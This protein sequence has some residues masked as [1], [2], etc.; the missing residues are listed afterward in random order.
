ME[1]LSKEK[2]LPCV[3]CGKVWQRKDVSKYV[4]HISRGVVCR[5]HY[6]VKEW[7]NNLLEGFTKEN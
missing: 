1:N 2:I 6:G 3:V 4:Y 7:Y 5:H